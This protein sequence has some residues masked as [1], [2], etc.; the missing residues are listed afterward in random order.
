MNSYLLIDESGL[1]HYPLINLPRSVQPSTIFS[2]SFPNENFVFVFVETV[3]YSDSHLFSSASH[4]C[5]SQIFFSLCS[6]LKKEYRQQQQHKNIAFDPHKR[7]Q[8]KRLS[9]QNQLSSSFGLMQRQQQQ[10]HL[11]LLLCCCGGSAVVARHN[12]AKGHHRPKS[13]RMIQ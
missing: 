8:Y 4:S 10:Q 13:K 2:W 1:G 5:L 11:R 7:A 3:I 6:K 9:N 12:N